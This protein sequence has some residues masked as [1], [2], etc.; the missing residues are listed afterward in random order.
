MTSPSPPSELRARVLEAA[1]RE[2]ARSRAHGARRRA[3]T[4]ALGFV[5]LA[6][7]ALAIGAHPG[8]RPSAY[9]VALAASWWVLAV[10]AT[11]AGV[12]RG[13]LMLGRSAFARIAVVM[14]TPLALALTG[15]LAG[16]IWPAALQ[17]AS[18]GYEDARCTLV[19]FLL[20]LG[21]LLAFARVR[22]ESEP[23]HP[24]LSG[25]ALGVAAG[26]WGAALL[27]VICAFARPAHMLIGHVL[28]VLWLAGIGAFVGARSLSIRP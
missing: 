4:I 22:R 19:T 9:I 5:A 11:W 21:P 15:L 8:R 26:T 2:P 17:D 28:P 3:F 20:A 25:A 7:T 27:V 12:G 24:R 13:R 10:G 1:R 18:G 16:R 23:I 14:V 6:L